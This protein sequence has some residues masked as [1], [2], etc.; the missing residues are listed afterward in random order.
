MRKKTKVALTA[1]TIMLA[2]T[3]IAFNVS[4]VTTPE[5]YCALNFCGLGTDNAEYSMVANVVINNVTQTMPVGT[6]TWNAEIGGVIIDD[7]PFVFPAR[8][9][10]VSL[11]LRIEQLNGYLPFLP[12]RNPN[13][14]YYANAVIRLYGTD[15]NGDFAQT[16][17]HLNSVTLFDSENNIAEGDFSPWANTEFNYDQITAIELEFTWTAIVFDADVTMEH[18][19]I[20]KFTIYQ[21]IPVEF[22]TDYGDD[23]Q[24]I[25]IPYDDEWFSTTGGTY[26]EGYYTGYEVGY[27]TGYD[28]GNDHGYEIGY[29]DG[30]YDGQNSIPDEVI[31]ANWTGFIYN[32]ANGFLRFKLLPGLPLW[33]LLMAAVA[34]PLLIAFLKMFMGG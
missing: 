20:T 17:A 21:S 18:V 22:P 25:F 23:V 12:H 8:S 31:E 33:G 15:T 9:R 32:A 29:D 24:H 14:T 6:Y 10:N 30:L 2:L 1:I 7:M 4:A 28:E 26:E 11:K 5:G 16:Y 13:D 3:A 19:D 27:N 34:I